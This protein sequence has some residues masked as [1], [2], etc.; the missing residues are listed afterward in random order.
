MRYVIT[1]NNTVK[2]KLQKAQL[3]VRSNPVAGWN[4]A[5][6]Y[7]LLGSIM[8]TGK[9]LNLPWAQSPL[10]VIEKRG[11]SHPGDIPPFIEFW[12]DTP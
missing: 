10:H 6:G 2:Q 8:E 9:A 7:R 5:V 1:R 12:V 11:I 4:P 3:G